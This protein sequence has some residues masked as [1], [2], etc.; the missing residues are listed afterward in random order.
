MKKTALYVVA[1]LLALCSCTKKDDYFEEYFEEWGITVPYQ[2]VSKTK[3]YKLLHTL[4]DDIDKNQIYLTHYPASDMYYPSVTKFNEYLMNSKDAAALFEREDCVYVLIST[5]LSYLKNSGPPFINEPWWLKDNMMFYFF[6][7]ILASEMF[8][9]KL[10]VTEQ[11]QL[12]ALALTSYV[13]VNMYDV[14]Y[15]VK[16]WN[17]MISIMLSSNYAPF[18]NDVKPMLEETKMGVS[19][20]LSTNGYSMKPDQINDLI[21]EY[22]TKFINDNKSITS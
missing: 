9:S 12:M 15:I 7:V 16:N 4:I 19:Y 8:T 1:V 21:I 14:E 6:R 20:W 11:V 17:I 10:N 5:Y 22:A 3:T 2:N 13:V 18:I